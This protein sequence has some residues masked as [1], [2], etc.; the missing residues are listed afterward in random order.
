MTQAAIDESG[1]VNRKAGM[2]LLRELTLL[3]EYQNKLLD[4]EHCAKLICNVMDIKDV[5]NLIE[6]LNAEHRKKLEAL[7]MVRNMLS[8]GVGLTEPPP[9]T[10]EMIRKTLPTFGDKPFTVGDMK[11]AIEGMFPNMKGR[12]R[13]ATLSGTCIRMADHKDSIRVLHR[14]SGQTPTTYVQIPSAVQ[15]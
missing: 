8:Q 6:Q 11:T 7:Y 10:S 5:E 14:G 15:V 12:L 1:H 9:S 13:I 2:M 4:M 3:P